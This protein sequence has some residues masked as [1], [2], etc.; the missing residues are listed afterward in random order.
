ML[1]F[2]PSLVFLQQTGALNA[3]YSGNTNIFKAH[4]A[5]QLMSINISHFPETDS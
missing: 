3:T 4:G 2:P 5:R 1:A